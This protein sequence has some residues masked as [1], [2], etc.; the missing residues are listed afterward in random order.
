MERGDRMGSAALR[1]D[2][3][4]AT[5]AL[6]ALSGHPE[7]ELHF[8]ERHAGAHMARNFAV[9]HS[10]TYANDHGGEAAVGWLFVRGLIINTNSSHLQS[11]SGIT[12]F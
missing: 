3:A 5:F 1:N 7:F 2:V 11:L 4:R 8:V 9:G 6:A 12:E 10:A